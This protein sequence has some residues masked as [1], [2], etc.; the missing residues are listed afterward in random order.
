M[1]L[2]VDGGGR[3]IPSSPSLGP[4]RPSSAARPRMAFV[5]TS[6]LPEPVPVVT[7]TSLSSE[8]KA[9]RASD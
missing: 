5:N 3:G 8:K 9:R 1:P 7:T 4:R 6:V 2:T